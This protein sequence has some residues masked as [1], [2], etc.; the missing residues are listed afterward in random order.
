MEKEPIINSINKLEKAQTKRANINLVKILKNTIFSKYAQIVIMLLIGGLYFKSEQNLKKYADQIT[1]LKVENAAKDLKIFNYQRKLSESKES[2]LV[3]ASILFDDVPIM[4]KSETVNKGRGLGDYGDP[5]L[6]TFA[7]WHPMFRENLLNRAIQLN[8][9]NVIKHITKSKNWDKSINE[10][11]VAK[12]FGAIDGKLEISASHKE[13]F[14][15]LFWRASSMALINDID[16]MN[17][18]LNKLTIKP[19]FLDDKRRENVITKAETFSNQLFVDGLL[20]REILV[21]TPKAHEIIDRMVKAQ[22]K[23]L[24]AWINFAEKQNEPKSATI[25]K[26]SN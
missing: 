20:T 3:V 24:K 15:K 16:E 10:N 26:I 14:W 6:F 12:A 7:Q 8:S 5:H 18:A 17:K 23:D 22:E 9:T 19:M 1:S 25:I 21:K 11:L 13:S 2:E 4:K